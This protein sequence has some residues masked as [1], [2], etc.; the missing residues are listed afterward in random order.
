MTTK[1]TPPTFDESQE[2]RGNELGTKG[3]HFG[4]EYDSHAHR[5]P[6]KVG[7][8]QAETGGGRADGGVGI[9][10]I[11]ATHAEGEDLTDDNGRRGWVDQ[12]TGEVHGSGAPAEDID[13]DVTPSAY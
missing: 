10:P 2:V 13:K 5:Q 8:G 6:R 12:R 11:A 7:V 9:D 1:I 4:N 3:P